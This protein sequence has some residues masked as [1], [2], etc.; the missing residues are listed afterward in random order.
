MS[1]TLSHAFIYVIGP[2]VVG[3]GTVL[4]A[5]KVARGS[6]QAAEVARE[7]EDR[8]SFVDGY[9]SLVGDLQTDVARLRK[10]HEELRGEHERL[11]GHVKDLEVQS[12]KDKSLIRAL[13]VY[14][15]LLRQEIRRLGGTVPIAP[16]QVDEE[17]TTDAPKG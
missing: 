16:Y 14:V 11:N 15:Q 10:D 4:A 12:I 2:L 8:A 7:S 13:T 6:V 9:H 3:V 5:F 17:V 1:S